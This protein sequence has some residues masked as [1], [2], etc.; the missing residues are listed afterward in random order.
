MRYYIPKNARKHGGYSRALSVIRD[1][2]CL[3][4]DLQTK[5][6]ND[7]NIHIKE[8]RRKIEAVETA[9]N[10]FS[11]E[12]Q[13]IIMERIYNKKRFSDIDARIGNQDKSHII[14]EFIFAVGH[15]LGEF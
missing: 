2:P 13:Q 6:S 4:R 9:L 7:S 3:K 12:Q 5:S 10:S 11:E 15:N 1:Y 8:L 14:Q